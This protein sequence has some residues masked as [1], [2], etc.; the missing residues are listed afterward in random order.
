MGGGDAVYAAWLKIRSRL[1]MSR[2][3]RMALEFWP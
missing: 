3:A 2:S 1:Q